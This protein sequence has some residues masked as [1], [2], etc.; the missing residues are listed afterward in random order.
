V[1]PNYYQQQ[2]WLLADAIAGRPMS[3]TLVRISTSRDDPQRAQ[4]RLRAFV[5]ALEAAR[6]TTM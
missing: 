2:L 1:T 6:H 4:Q 3:G 5:E